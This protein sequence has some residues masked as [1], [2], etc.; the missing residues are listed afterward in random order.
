MNSWLTFWS[1]FMHFRDKKIIFSKIQEIRLW[2]FGRIFQVYKKNDRKPK[3]CDKA[4][5]NYKKEN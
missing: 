4:K 3:S 5:L 2:G 1:S